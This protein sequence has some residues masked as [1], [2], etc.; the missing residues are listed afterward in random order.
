[1]FCYLHLTSLLQYNDIYNFP[2]MAFDAALK[3]EEVSGESESEKSDD[4]EVEREMEPELER[5][6]QKNVEEVDEFVEADSDMESDLVSFVFKNNFCFSLKFFQCLDA[7][8]CL[9]NSK[10]LVCPLF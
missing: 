8:F 10:F 7:R 1:M 2:Q 4:E 6:L 3:A 5:E 9:Q